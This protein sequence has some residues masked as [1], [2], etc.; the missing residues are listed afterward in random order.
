MR[1]YWANFPIHSAQSQQADTKSDELKVPDDQ[2][3]Q[4]TESYRP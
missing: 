1:H 4:V 3:A 2:T